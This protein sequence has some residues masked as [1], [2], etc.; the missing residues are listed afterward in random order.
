M[1]ERLSAALVGQRALPKIEPCLASGCLQDFLGIPPDKLLK[2]G[3]GRSARQC[4]CLTGGGTALDHESAFY[5]ASFNQ[6]GMSC[7]F[8]REERFETGNCRC[9]GN[10]F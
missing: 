6:I 4:R 9:S 10:L 7:W 3:Q 8:R 1:G 2:L 5:E